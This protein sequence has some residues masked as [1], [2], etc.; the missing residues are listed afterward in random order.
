MV[1]YA[2]RYPQYGWESN[3]GYASEEHMAAIDRYG[4]SP[5][6]RASFCTSMTQ[7]ALF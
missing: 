1:D 7:M 3:K 4:L 2:A 5:L 6:H